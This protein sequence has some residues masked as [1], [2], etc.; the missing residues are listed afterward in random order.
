[1]KTDKR[2][3]TNKNCTWVDEL[4]KDPGIA[5]FSHC[6]RSVLSSIAKSV[7]VAPDR[8]GAATQK[9]P[10]TCAFKYGVISLPLPSSM[11]PLSP[12]PPPLHTHVQRQTK[13]KLLS[14]TCSQG[15]GQWCKILVSPRLELTGRTTF[16][17]MQLKRK[18]RHGWCSLCVGEI[19]EK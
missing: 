6:W 2:S 12:S 3:K 11:S 7:K 4:M 13:R 1:M 19:G 17:L 10:M 18:D 14:R 15:Q 16:V 9:E 5:V 8:V